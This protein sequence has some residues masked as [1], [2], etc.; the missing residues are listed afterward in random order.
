VRKAVPVR[1][2]ARL[3][4]VESDRAAAILG[5]TYVEAIVE[6]VLRA[7]LL[8]HRDVDAMF[9]RFGPFSSFATKTAMLFA[10]GEINE[11]TRRD[12]DLIRKIRNEFAHTFAESD[13]EE[14]KIAR[15]CGEL[16]GAY[17]ASM[18]AAEYPARAQ[19]IET[20]DL[21]REVLKER[22]RT[23]RRGRRR[24]AIPERES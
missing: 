9:D 11:T 12:L 16:T 19:F 20:V 7:C 10:I 2:F 13:F 22:A 1:T 6:D 18:G 15:W 4:R 14:A 3:F 5:A 24:A 21:V 17:A 23:R 8:E